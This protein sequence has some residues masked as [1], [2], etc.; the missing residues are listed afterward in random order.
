[1]IFL[2]RDYPLPSFKFAEIEQQL[3]EE[4][5]QWKLR[6]RKCDTK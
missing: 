1:M 3:Q 4:V 2:I 6:V 5:L